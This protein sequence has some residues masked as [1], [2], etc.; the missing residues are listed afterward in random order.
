MKVAPLLLAVVAACF[1]VSGCGYNTLK[2]KDKEL[3]SAWQVLDIAYQQRVTA[4]TA[5]ASFFQN[6]V[7]DQQQLMREVRDATV[8]AARLGT[9]RRA[10]A[11]VRDIKVYQGVQD[12]LTEALAK[13]IVVENRYAR[14]QADPRHDLL[15]RQLEVTEALINKASVDFQM[16]V[17]DFNLTKQSFPTSLANLLFLRYRDRQTFRSREEVKVAV[18]AEPADSAVPAMP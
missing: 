7:H 14:I 11:S 8:R 6:Y 18:T 9:S 13:L 17:H 4:A 1:L 15:H 5:Y 12:E 10:P 2:T 3:E 16:A